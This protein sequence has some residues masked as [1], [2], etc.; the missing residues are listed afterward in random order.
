[1]KKL[2]TIGFLF[3]SLQSF[4]SSDLQNGLVAYYPF[5]GDAKDKSGHSADLT[6]TGATL[7]KD[8]NNN[9]NSA[10]SFNGTSDKMTSSV[11]FGSATT[12]TVAA[13][14]KTSESNL[15]FYLNLV[16][17][18]STDT[19]GEGLNMWTEQGEAGLAVS[20]PG[21]NSA[22]GALVADEWTHVAGTYDGTNIKFYVN[23][24]LK[25]TTKWVGSFALGVCNLEIG[26]QDNIYWSG[27]I[28]EV[29]IYNRV[30]SEAEIS[31]LK[32]TKITITTGILS[33]SG[34]NKINAYPVPAKENLY[35]DDNRLNENSELIIVNAQGSAVAKKNYIKN[36]PVDISNLEGGLYFIEVLSGEKRFSIKFI[37]E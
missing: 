2:F 28:D 23:G 16:L 10:Y 7:V 27:S 26:F 18:S 34:V 19:D 21:T 20:L 8:R 6:V 31:E 22:S 5:D 17:H 29:A 11:D 9:D 37:K 30:L 3:F 15:K 36:E 32:D 25:N 14:I 1:M 12:Y 13:W 33:S 35:L 4:S 24:V